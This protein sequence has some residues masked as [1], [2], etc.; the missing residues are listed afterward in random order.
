MGYAQ[1]IL[2]LPV[3]VLQ[4]HIIS[5]CLAKSSLNAVYVQ[6]YCMR[7]LFA[8]KSCRFP[9]N[10]DSQQF[11]VLSFK[12]TWGLYT[13]E[14]VLALCKEVS[15]FLFFRML[16]IQAGMLESAFWFNALFSFLQKSGFRLLLKRNS[17][18]L[19]HGSMFSELYRAEGY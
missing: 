5:L 11:F 8:L 12:L 3:L 17:R 9:E 7:V 18:A 6:L 2:S 14:I 10:S 13:F 4:Q 19:R 15:G 1:D 16:L